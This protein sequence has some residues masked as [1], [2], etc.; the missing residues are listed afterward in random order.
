MKVFEFGFRGRHVCR[1]PRPVS[2]MTWFV[3]GGAVSS[4]ATGGLIVLLG[5]HLD[6][7]VRAIRGQ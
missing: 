1:V 3:V 4:V 6:L 2:R 7:V 5:G